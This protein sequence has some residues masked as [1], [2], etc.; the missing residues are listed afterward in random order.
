MRTTSCQV[1]CSFEG[2]KEE[3][4]PLRAAM[5]KLSLLMANVKS[6]IGNECA[7]EFRM[8]KLTIMVVI[9]KLF[10]L[11]MASI[12]IAMAIIIKTK[13]IAHRHSQTNVRTKERE[14]DPI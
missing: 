8:E 13:I 1:C 12:I 6:Y 2:A 10:P 11:L 7:F 9:I 3:V 14:R 5:K 4:A